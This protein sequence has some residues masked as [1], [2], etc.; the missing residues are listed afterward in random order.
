MSTRHAVIE[1]VLGELTL[2]ATDD[3][4]TGLY[5]PH[6]WHMPPR[7]MFGSPVEIAGDD[8]IAEAG[9]QLAQ[10]WRANAQGSL[11]RQVR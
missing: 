8:L 6:H 11:F 1:S 5:F 7:E 3:A 2:V 4:M 9:R 10:S